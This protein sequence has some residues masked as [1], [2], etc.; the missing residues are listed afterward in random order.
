MTSKGTEYPDMLTAQSSA[1]S[2]VPLEVTYRKELN[3]IC[4]IRVED[5]IHLIIISKVKS[6]L[7]RQAGVI[8]LSCLMGGLIEVMDK[9]GGAKGFT[10][11]LFIFASTAF[12]AS[13]LTVCVSL[14]FFFD[15]FA[16]ECS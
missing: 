15:D 8:I 5:Y 11:K 1:P 16:S 13:A 4:L 6:K 10:D 3:P 2:D 12:H 14:A 9:S 7:P